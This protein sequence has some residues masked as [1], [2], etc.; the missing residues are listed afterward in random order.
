APLALD[1]KAFG[2][3]DRAADD[4]IQFARQAAQAFGGLDAVINLVPLAL[5]HLEPSASTS[6]V[7]RI[8][9]ARLLLPC[10]LS[11]I[12]ANR[13]A[14]SWTEGL[15]LNVATLTPPA[16]GTTRAFACVTKAALAAM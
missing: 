11:K 6:D 15:I 3:V 12:A 14:I 5:A 2:P 16:Q 8:V 10:L 1:I 9:A 4:V 7:E 13:M